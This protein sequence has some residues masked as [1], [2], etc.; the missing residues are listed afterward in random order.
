MDEFYVLSAQAPVNTPENYK[1][2]VIFFRKNKDAAIANVQLN[3]LHKLIQNALK[4]EL[5]DFL[6]ADLNE[7]P[8]RISVLLKNAAVLKCFLFGVEEKEAGINFDLP[9]YQ[10][11]TV[12][13]IEFL[14]A[15]APETLEHNKNL[16]NK[17]WSQLQISFNLP[18]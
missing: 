4:M 11:I 18:G 2:Y 8:L 12:A 13:G 17:L 15:D 5:G 3:L 6:F 7:H 9:M 10:L 16:K 1:G 14:K